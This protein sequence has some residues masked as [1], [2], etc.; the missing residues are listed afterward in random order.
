MA[1][2]L[3]LAGVIGVYL[4]CSW[5]I[6]Y[7]YRPNGWWDLLGEEG[8]NLA[9][10]HSVLTGGVYGKDFHCLYGPLLV[11]PL[12]WA[13]ELFGVTIITERAYTFCLNL[14]AYGIII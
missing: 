2:L 7:F 6:N 8:E 12:A 13:M 3:C 14:A 5:N 9:W 11:Y 10:A 4:V 1:W